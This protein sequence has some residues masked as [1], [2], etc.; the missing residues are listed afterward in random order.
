SSRRLRER[1]SPSLKRIAGTVAVPMGKFAM[2]PDWQPDADFIRLAALWG[3]ALREP[4]TTEELASFI[5]YWQA[6]G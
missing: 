3:V 2:Y 4:V 6:E 5:A 1:I